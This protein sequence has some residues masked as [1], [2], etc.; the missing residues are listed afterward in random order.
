[1]RSA[2][3]SSS[4]A[5]AQAFEQLRDVGQRALD[6][7]GERRGPADGLEQVAPGV[8]EAIGRAG[9]SGR[10]RAAGAADLALQGVEDQPLRLGDLPGL[11]QR[12]DQL[13][14]RGRERD[15]DPPERGDP[16]H[17]VFERLAQLDRRRAQ[18]LA[19]HRRQILRQAERAGEGLA[20]DR[21]E[22]GED[23]SGILHALGGR[24]RRGFDP[25]GK[26]GD[27]LCRQP[28]GVTRCLEHRLEPA[29]G[30][31]GQRRLADALD[32]DGAHRRQR[33]GDAETDRAEA[34]E[35]GAQRTEPSGHRVHAAAQLSGDAVE[36]QERA[37]G[38]ARRILDA[39]ERP[40]AGLA[41]IAQ[42][43]L[44]LAAVDDGQA[45]GKRAIS[46]GA[47]PRRW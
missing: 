9:Q 3:G 12:A 23:R 42:L 26:S 18:I 6:H 17:R 4:S 33:R 45:N 40:A 36:G 35:P 27:L 44:D 19:E 28:R 16:L 14:L 2:I 5:P 43:G 32:D 22:G 46:H 15:P 41:D 25:F 37:R 34:G 10:F 30:L 24:Q 11:D 47:D 38:R 8:G 1:M 29:I 31:L 20:G 21:A 39:L 13:A 7:A